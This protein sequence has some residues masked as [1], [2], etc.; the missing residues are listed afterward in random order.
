MRSARMYLLYVRT[1]YGRSM[2][3]CCAAPPQ[4]TQPEHLT[5]RRQA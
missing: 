2:M 1:Y 3:L 4:R 5:A